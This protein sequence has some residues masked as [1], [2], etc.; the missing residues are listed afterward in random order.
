MT[1]C[2]KCGRKNQGELVKNRTK[3][4][5]RQMALFRNM[6]IYLEL[7]RSR[8]LC[9]NCGHTFNRSHL[10]HSRINFRPTEA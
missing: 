3:T 1:H 9:R 8:F 10:H 6:L 2:E 4:T 7:K 5:R